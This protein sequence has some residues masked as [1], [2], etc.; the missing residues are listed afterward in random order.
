MDTHEAIEKEPMTWKR[1]LMIQVL[2]FLGLFVLAELVLRCFGM[3]AGT[4]IDD[5]KIQEHPVYEPRFTS[6]DMGI[7]YINKN[8]TS[9]MLGTRINKLGLRDSVEYTPEVVDSIKRIAKQEAIMIVGDSYVEGCCPDTVTNSFPDIINRNK[10]F[11]VLNFGVS[12]TDPLQ[13]QLVAQKYLPILRPDK[14][15]VVFYFG[16]DI[17]T[18]ER[19]AT[20]NAPLTFPFKDNKWIFGVAPNHLSQKLNHSFTS[21]EEAYTFY[22]DKYT[23]RGT[24][25]NTLERLLSYSVICSKLYLYMEHRNARKLW[26]SKGIVYNWDGFEIAYH[27]LS[28]I[29][30]LADSLNIE[31]LFVGIPSPEE[32]ANA[33]NLTVKYKALFKDIKWHVPA[34]LTKEDYDGMS[35]SNHFNNEGHKK[36]AAFLGKLILK[37]E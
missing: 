3:Q 27:R 23:L 9:L 22:M 2:V 1:R 33:E 19:K 35:I 37:E 34:N 31:S 24:T 25:R 16:N 18:F 30:K 20:P 14:I 12:G 10:H 13:Y 6:D 36:Y 8:A 7:N 28:T 32:A 21:A 15:V 5:F 17:L 4:L 26:E 11:K 29:K